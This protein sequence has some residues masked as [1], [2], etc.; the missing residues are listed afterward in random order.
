MGPRVW[1]SRDGPFRLGPMLITGTLVTN[2]LIAL[3]C[4]SARIGDKEGMGRLL[5]DGRKTC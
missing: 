2:G 4:A 5:H 3:L 1:W